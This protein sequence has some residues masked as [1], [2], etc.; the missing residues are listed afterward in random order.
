MSRTESTEKVVPKDAPEKGAEGQSRLSFADLGDVASLNPAGKK[1]EIAGSSNDG[2][3]P[4]FDTG[5]LFR[6]SSAFFTGSTRDL[7]ASPEAGPV[8]QD[9]GQDA[10]QDAGQGPGQD[11]RPAPGRNDQADHKKVASESSSEAFT[12]G[13]RNGARE[14]DHVDSGVEPTTHTLKEGESLADL[15]ARYGKPSPEELEAFKKAVATINGVDAENIKPGTELKLPGTDESGNFVHEQNGTTMRWWPNGSQVDTPDGDRIVSLNDGTTTMSGQGKP[16][17]T[18]WADGRQRVHQT[19]GTTIDR[20]ADGSQVETRID[21][22]VT[23]TDS[24]G[25]IDSVESPIATLN[26]SFKKIQEDD[27]SFVDTSTGARPG[28]DY[29]LKGTGKEGDMVLQEGDKELRFSDNPE[30]AES[31]Q[32]LLDAARARIDNPQELSKFTADMIRFENR[33]REGNLSPEEIKKT[34]EATGRLLADNP[35]APVDQAGR[36]QIAEQVMAQAAIPTGIDQGFHNTCNVTTVESALYT[37]MP[38]KAA[39]LVADVATTGG[40]TAS[41][42]T[43]VTVPADSIGPDAESGLNPPPDGKRS[44]ASQLFQVAAINAVYQ[45]KGGDTSYHQLANPDPSKPGDTGERLFDDRQTPPKLKGDAPGFNSEE[46]AQSY[47]LISGQDFGGRMLDNSFNSIRGGNFATPEELHDRL[48]ELSKN[49]GFPAILSVNA[50]TKPFSSDSGRDTAAGDVGGSHVVTV[51]GYDAEKRQLMIDNQWGSNKDHIDKPVPLEE[52]FYATMN[53]ETGNLYRARQDVE[54]NHPDL[55]KT[56]TDLQVLAEHMKTYPDG[57]A[58]LLGIYDAVGNADKAWQQQRKD[59]TFD[60]AEHDKTTGIMNEA[61]DQLPP[62]RNLQ[63]LGVR[64]LENGGSY[65]DGQTAYQGEQAFYDRQ[66]LTVAGKS[67]LTG[68]AIRDEMTR[69]AADPSAR[70]QEGKEVLFEAARVMKMLKP[71][72][73]DAL[74]R[75]LASN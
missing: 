41:D 44:Y 8:T 48:T 35:G 9:N 69:L 24:E 14:H 23:R 19:D 72:E 68:E 66:F 43:R 62:Q 71:E 27:G 29:T 15:A 42:G 2:N 17:I 53:P 16:T 46:I 40:F 57:G 70:P 7:A 54:R 22:R 56:Q 58:A 10:G 3:M 67:G 20:A 36:T 32:A 28:F 73:Q 37:T 61:F 1:T 75:R 65:P 25:R 59:G 11:N 18:T 5:S 26:G 47:K 52:A 31:R 63:M 45:S 12:P 74:L 4:D 60:Q 39:N 50:F 51:T 34:Y 49:G 33:A 64:L 38:S 55:T 30:L 13:D 21:G 6:D